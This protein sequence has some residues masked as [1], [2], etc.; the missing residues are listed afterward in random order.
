MVAIRPTV[1]Y[2]L[3]AARL[4]KTFFNVFFLQITK[5]QRAELEATK[6]EFE[7]KQ[8]QERKAME[9]KQAETL[10]QMKQVTQLS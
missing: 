4:V 5:E 6:A 10:E 8:A 3:A 2:D 1:T 9:A 7:A